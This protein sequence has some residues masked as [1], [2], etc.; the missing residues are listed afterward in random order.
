MNS[1]QLTKIFFVFLLFT[2]YLSL[3]TAVNAE[4]LERV[5]AIVD[6][7]VV[8][9]SEFNE[10]FQRAFSPQGESAEAE[11]SGR[12]ITQDEVLDSLINRILLLKEAK[13]FNLA[14]QTR[15]DDNAL[16]NEYIERRLRAFIR[17]PFDEIESFY[18]E[19]KDSLKGKD[20]YDVKDEIEEYLIE[21]K[22]NKRLLNHIEELRE[23]A[24]IRIQLVTEDDASS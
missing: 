5:V 14:I 18:K 19:N 23:K 21:E 8:M 6:D 4:V 11:K 15:K 10:A 16:I 24:Y 20:F 17:I 13:K 7:E 2:H 12:E 22:L 1:K 9:L 3:I